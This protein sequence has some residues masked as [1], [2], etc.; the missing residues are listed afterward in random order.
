MAH[1][2]LW[3]SAA[4]VEIYHGIHRS[5]VREI[6]T[7]KLSLTYRNARWCHHQITIVATEGA[8]RIPPLASFSPQES[9][10]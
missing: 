7:V 1:F 10:P 8:A 5:N 6:I 9:P 4:I 3:Y 2:I